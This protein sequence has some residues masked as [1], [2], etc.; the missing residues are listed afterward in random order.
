MTLPPPDQIA[1]TL[2]QQGLAGRRQIEAQASGPDDILA[3]GTVLAAAPES[4]VRAV[5][6]NI[7]ASLAD[8]ISLPGLLAALADPDPAV[9]AAA[10]DAIGNSAYDQALPEELRRELGDRLLALMTDDA[11]PREVRTA[12]QYALGLLRFEPALP[13]LIAALDDDE[14]M[15]RW[16]SA[17]ALAHIGDPSAAPA[18]RQRAE[19]EQHPRVMRF[20]ETALQELEP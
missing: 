7:L 20:L 15:I 18:L 9:I 6:A 8:P 19:R 14:A 10:A 13:A 1:E 3:L 11:Q 12:S 4:R 2:R 17:E 5:A 16:N